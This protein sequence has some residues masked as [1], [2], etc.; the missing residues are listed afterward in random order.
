L[1]NEL[2]S[3]YDPIYVP[4]KTPSGKH[5]LIPTYEKPRRVYAV[6]PGRKEES[7]RETQTFSIAFLFF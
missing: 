1:A 3:Q 6:L 5:P 7:P 4:P 2:F